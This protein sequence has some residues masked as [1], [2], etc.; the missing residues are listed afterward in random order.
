MQ[1]SLFRSHGALFLAVFLD[2]FSFGLMYPLI[3]GLFD[4]AGAGGHG[5]GGFGGQVTAANRD[6]M[7]SLAFALF[8][9]GAFFGCALLGDLSDALG[10]RR[11]LVVCMAGLA[12]GYGLMWLSLELAH[13]WLFF[14]G[15]I[16]AGLMSGTAPIAQA[17]MVD[18]VAPAARGD[19]MA[20]VTV[21]NTVGLMAGPA[22]GGVLGHYDFRLPLGVA[23]VLCAFNAV[24]LARSRFGEETRRRAFHFDWRQPFL[25]F[26][27]LK[28]RPQVVPALASFFLFQ[29]GFLI[30]YTFILVVMQRDHGFSTAQI[31]LFSV[32]M[33][34][35]F[36]LGSAL[37]YAPVAKWLKHERRIAIF[38]EATCGGL[39]VLTA[40]PVGAAGQVG[41]AVLICIA[42]VFSYVSLLSAMS[43]AVDE[44]ERG[45][46]MGLSSASVALCVFIAGL[47]TSLLATLPAG[48]FLAAGGVL[49][50]LGIA[51]ALRIPTLGAPVQA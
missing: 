6:L 39:L 23:L 14:A 9:I 8:P 5:F 28:A 46:V 7:M 3:V 40:L 25:L 42:N 18:A 26:A 44:T 51:P 4:G 30:Y 43:G 48:V 19:A 27:R 17:S 47:L 45:W 31:G 22:I 2:I 1:I 13:V 38:G 12:A 37:G 11:T 32:A 10:R 33:G 49:V 50:L 36:M 20:Q 34:I 21:V 29:L 16:V 15:R 24:L 35:G 41:L